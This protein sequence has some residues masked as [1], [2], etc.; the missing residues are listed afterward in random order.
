MKEDDLLNR[1]RQSAQPAE[2]PEDIRPENIEKKL[3][4]SS[5]SKKKHMVRRWAA[6]VG[7]AACVGLAL[8]SW[9][10]GPGRGGSAKSV[11]ES[12]QYKEDTGADA[13]SQPA[14]EEGDI[15]EPAAVRKEVSQVMAAASDYREVY[16]T[17]KYPEAEVYEED[18]G[19]L[20]TIADW[21]EGDSSA[22]TEDKATTESSA[23]TADTG[24]AGGT[25]AAD[26]P[27]NSYSK[28]NV[29]E[30][31]VDEADIV[32]TDGSYLY[33]ATR[34]GELQ[35]V[36]A[37]GAD[38][39][40]VSTTR[41]EASG[42]DIREMYVDGNTLNLITSV[43]ETTLYEREKN[44]YDTVS[45]ESANLYTYDITDRSKIKQT[46]HLSQEGNYESS[47][48]VGQYIYLFTNYVPYSTE[49]PEYVD[50]YVPRVNGEPLLAEDIFLPKDQTMSSYIV[51]SSVDLGKPDTVKETKAL[52]AGSEMLYVSSSNIYITRPEWEKEGER[53]S[54]VRFAYKDGKIQAEAAA[55]V[56][57]YLKDS[58]SLDEYEGKLRLVV[59]SYSSG[60]DSN[61]LYILDE[62]LETL[63]SI[64]N[65]A[66]GEQIKS[67][68]FMGDKGYFVTFRNTDPLF[69]VDLSDPRNP[70]ILGQLKI[71]GFSE[72][73]HFYG[74]NLLLGIGRDAD[75]ETGKELGLKLSMFDITDPANVTEKSKMVLDSVSEYMGAQNYKSI[76]IDPEKNIFGF[77]YTEGP[78][79]PAGDYE[80]AYYAVFS[81]EEGT[82]FVN[83]LICPLN[84]EGEW[85]YENF[86]D[87]RGLYSNHILYIYNGKGIAAYDMDQNY[88]QVGELT[89]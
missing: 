14:A 82:G 1:I 23:D 25:G 13:V 53:T 55:T 27:E 36:K 3:G 4:S 68:R 43:Y 30:E 19:V 78:S 54:L 64:E 63:G 24:A 83:R 17:V 42:E 89:W 61:A 41:L 50:G 67:A 8:L 70:V 71:P 38:M 2:I 59:T 46:G 80:Y 66:E 56:S 35:I 10:M 57:G 6:G 87:A 32:K 52:V 51:I 12:A 33:I 31:G 28:T 75:P 18:R 84:E 9:T 20:G 85:S 40:I 65:L 45:R 60:I 86:M 81:Y 16:D 5:Q 22:S 48:K 7:A 62:N 88:E 44:T 77:A 34:E 76:M 15:E 72:Y 49:D 58:F 69:S 39:K 11:S 73:L 21:L 74:E 29:R 37:D 79:S 26:T 47:R